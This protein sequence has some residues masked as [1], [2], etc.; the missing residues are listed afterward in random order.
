M[1][2]YGMVV[3]L[4]K[5]MGCKTCMV[6]CKVENNTPQGI[7]WMYVYR[8]EK[9]KYP[10]AK[11]D[12][13]PKPCMQC[14]KPPCVQV[15]P[16]GATFKRED[17]IIL[18][19]YDQCIGCKFCMQACPYAARYFNEKRHYYF[20]WDK[21][22]A[23][24]YGKGNIGAIVPHTPPYHNPDHNKTYPG[25]HGK[26]MYESGGIAYRGVVTKCTFCVHRLAKGLKPACVANCPVN[27]LHFGDLDDPNSE[28]SKMLGDRQYNVLKPEKGTKPMVYYL[29]KR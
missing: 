3:D 10:N 25:K 17:G 23:N 9:G 20:E 27:A 7:F 15:C 28:V 14:D 12:F 29:L 13:L 2:R 21:G 16:V 6:A 19:N 5:C 24:T 11:M 1:V 8:K 18:V 4:E 22:G 26:P